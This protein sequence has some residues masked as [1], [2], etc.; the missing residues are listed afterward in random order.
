MEILNKFLWVINGEQLQLKTDA[1][2]WP[3][4]INLKIKESLQNVEH[5]IEKFE[6]LH[7][8]DELVLQDRVEYI[9]GAITQLTIENNLQRVLKI[10]VGV[11]KNWKF[12]SELHSFGLILNRRQKIFGHTVCRYNCLYLQ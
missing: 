4:K 1:M 8:E 11:N 6:K 7:L 10:A 5:E 3:Y 12:I 9:S 2:L